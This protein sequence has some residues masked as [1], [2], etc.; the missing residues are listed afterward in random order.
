MGAGGRGRAADEVTGAADLGRARGSVAAGVMAFRPVGI[1]L[2]GVWQVLSTRWSGGGGGFGQVCPLFLPFAMGLSVVA[3]ESSALTWSVRRAYRCG[4]DGFRG[5][6]SPS[7]RRHHAS[8]LQPI[9]GNRGDS[10]RKLRSDFLDRAMAASSDVVSSLKALPLEPLL[11]AVWSA[12]MKL[13]QG[14]WLRVARA[15][16]CT[17][18]TRRGDLSFAPVAGE[19]QLYLLSLM[20]GV[21]PYSV[22]LERRVVRFSGA[23]CLS[24]LL[25]NARSQGF[26]AFVL[27]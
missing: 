2:C 6:R 5:R 23:T 12:W 8:P 25:C 18:C 22:S 9:L 4:D 24:A 19:A 11:A 3:S 13:G 20:L 14:L 26:C 1:R 27:E 21:V 7:W 10:E 16:W 17:S 15:H